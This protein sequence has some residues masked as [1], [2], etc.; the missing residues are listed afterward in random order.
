MTNRLSDFQLL[1]Q[2]SDMQG[3]SGREGKVR[4][5]IHT[6]IKSNVDEI[7]IDRLG[8]LVAHIPGKGKRVMIVAHMDE[9]GLIVQRIM[10]NG[11]LQVERLGGM[12]L[13]ALPGSRLSLWTDRGCLPAYAV[14]KP[15]HLDGFEKFDIS[16]V[17]I[18]VG[19]S[20]K[21]A[22]IQMGIRVGDV[23]T[24]DSPLRTFGNDRISAKALDDRLG[25][26]I[27]IQLTKQ[28]NP[29]DLHC[30]L[31]L[32]FT[33]QEETMLT[34][35]VS[36]A[37]AFSPDIIVGVDGTLTFDSPDIEGQQCDLRLG[38]GP[39]IKW[40]DAIRGKLACFVPNYK[41]AEKIRMIAQQA[42]IPL[43]DE[44]VTNISTAITPMQYAGDGAAAVAL[45]IPI[46]YHH[47]PIETAN[48]HD[49]KNMISL[50][51]SIVIHEL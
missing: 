23:L 18:D 3:V 44:V 14:I 13:R 4:E 17:F 40:M 37:R 11:F 26:Y 1:K 15:Q 16:K 20:S 34:G 51:N 43:Q 32:A 36:V 38:A 9:V 50:L 46:R 41:I 42:N 27:L 33:V 7:H 24:W 21:E 28:L 2:L 49:V 22:I 25:C 48:V 31:Y 19:A 12:S 10:P 8:N 47:T 29:Q 30:D 39:A 35:G 5:I 45:S 6:S